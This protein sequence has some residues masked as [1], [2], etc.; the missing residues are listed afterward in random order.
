MQRIQQKVKEAEAQA[1]AAREQAITAQEEAIAAR[2]ELDAAF[3]GKANKSSTSSVTLQ[4][5]TESVTISDEDGNAM[6]REWEDEINVI[7]TQ[8]D[9]M[10]FALNKKF[11]KISD[12]L[13]HSENAESMDCNKTAGKQCAE[14]RSFQ[15]AWKVGRPWL[16][17][18]NDK[19]YCTSCESAGKKNIFTAGCTHLK[20]HYI[21][22][23]ENLDEHKLAV[24]APRLANEFQVARMN[25]ITIEVCADA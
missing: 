16:Q 21:K 15:P 24:D 5:H 2:A 17:Y 4:Q 6:E 20:A 3:A 10:F 1:S 9:D 19:M 14:K 18:R 22:K 8:E 13:S 11:A 23:H 12:L 7:Q 25:S